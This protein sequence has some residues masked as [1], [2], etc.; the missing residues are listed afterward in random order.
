MSGVP[1]KVKVQ[2]R[3]LPTIYTPPPL[4]LAILFLILP[5][6]MVK[7]V[8]PWLPTLTPPPVAAVFP[9]MLPPFM[10]NLALAELTPP[11]SVPAVLFVISPSY[12]VKAEY[13]PLVPTPPPA[14]L[15]L[16]PE[17]TPPYRLKIP[18]SPLALSIF[19]PPPCSAVLPVMLP[20][21]ILNRVPLPLDSVHEE[22]RSTPLPVLSTA[23]VIVPAVC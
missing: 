8:E 12:M 19:T 21:Y 16:L 3:N 22:Y 1:F 23:W 18:P 2:E 9:V 15:A 17:I 6:F 7:S 13:R 14:S 4:V 10:M 20:P 11:P 5:P